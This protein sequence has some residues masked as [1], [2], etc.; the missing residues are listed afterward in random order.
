MFSKPKSGVATR[1]L[2]V[3]NCGPAV[4]LSE[5]QV[6]AYFE[7]TG[8]QAVTFPASDRGPSSHV[9]VTCRDTAEAKAKLDA[10]NGKPVSEL[11]DRRL[12]IKFAGKKSD[13]LDDEVTQLHLLGILDNPKDAG[14]EQT[15]LI[16]MFFVGSGSHQACTHRCQ[17]MWHRRL[18]TPH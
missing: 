7:S 11:G 9:F 17:N 8:A 15:S 5:I 1:H 2:F 4:G 3:G 12:V 6:K 16:T 13:K 14:R 18:G 10:L